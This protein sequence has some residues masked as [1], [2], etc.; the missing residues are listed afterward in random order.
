MTAQEAAEQTK[1][2]FDDMVAETILSGYVVNEV[3][4]GEIE[5]NG[6]KMRVYIGIC[7]D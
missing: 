5:I 4:L 1:K 7:Q 3:D 6:K 2:E